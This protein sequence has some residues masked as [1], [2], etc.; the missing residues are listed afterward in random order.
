LA[1]EIIVVIA[2]SPPWLLW[3]H[4][5]GRA[6]ENFGQG[7][8]KTLSESEKVMARPI[9][10]KK[11]SCL[12]RVYAP[13]TPHYRR[14]CHSGQTP[15]LHKRFLIPLTPFFFSSLFAPVPV[16]VQIL[17]FAPYWIWP[18]SGYIHKF[19]NHCTIL[20]DATEIFLE[21]ALLYGVLGTAGPVF[22]KVK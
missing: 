21:L 10:L 7:G 14:Q 12:W 5:P 20:L 19:T 18:F 15:L 6:I 16:P 4:K 2:K 1:G 8:P 17:G 22:N 13:W 3:G 9:F 11:W